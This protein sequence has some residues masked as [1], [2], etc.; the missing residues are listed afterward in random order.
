LVFADLSGKGRPTDVLVKTRYRRIW[1]Y[2]Q[3]GELLWN[4]TDPGGFRTA[5]QARP[6]DID[7]DGFIW[8]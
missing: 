2:D 5:H 3:G 8:C 1:A 6:I 7:G 4:V